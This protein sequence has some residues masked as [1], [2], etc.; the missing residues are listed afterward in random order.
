MTRTFHD[1]SI[2]DTKA[3]LHTR[4]RHPGAADAVPQPQAGMTASKRVPSSRPARVPRAGRS[5][6]VHAPR[7]MGDP[8][9]LR[10]RPHNAVDLRGGTGQTKLARDRGTPHGQAPLSPWHP[11]GQFPRSLN[12]QHWAAR[13]SRGAG[14]I[15]RS[16][17]PHSVEL[18]A[19]RCP[20]HLSSC[21]H[22]LS[23]HPVFPWIPA[24]RLPE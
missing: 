13:T 7:A 14:G 19:L 1:S 8:D 15:P 4:G 16:K 22:F 11:V 10:G 24:K 2:S 17:R 20:F 21:R 9:S 18:H 6:P 3:S 23:R 5:S 12:Q